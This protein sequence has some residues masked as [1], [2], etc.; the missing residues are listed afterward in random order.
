M[1]WAE[2]YSKANHSGKFYAA[3]SIQT[4]ADLKELTVVLS[5]KNDA[6]I[7]L[8]ALTYELIPKTMANHLH[9]MKT[10]AIPD[11]VLMLYH[12]SNG[13]VI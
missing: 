11:H 3:G 6:D 2:T 5:Q 8:D 12:Y 4:I 7:V 1:F 13:R 10:F 9:K